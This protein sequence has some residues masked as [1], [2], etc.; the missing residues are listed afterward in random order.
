MKI[1]VDIEST[2][3]LQNGLDYSNL[4]YALK[5]DYKIWC[6]VFRNITTGEVTHLVKDKI[7]KKNMQQQLQ[8]CTELI[9]HN[10]VQFDLPVLMLYGVLDYRVG[11]PGEPTTVF[12]QEVTITDTLLWSKLLN[13]DR[14]GGHSLAVWGKRLGNYKEHFDDWANY[15]QEMLDYCIQDTFVNESIYLKLLEE[16]GQ[17][18]WSKPYSVEIKLADLTLRQELF[19]FDF[20]KE[21]AE[22][23]LQELAGFMQVIA[24]KVNPLLPLKQMPKSDYSFYIPPKVR[25]KKDGSISSHMD[26]FLT[27]L[28]ASLQD[29]NQSIV[30]EGRSFP[31]TTE[32]P[33][34]STTI[35]TIEDIDVVK[36]Y[37][38]GLGWFPTEIK[39]RDLVKNQD[40]TTKNYAQI[41]EAIDRYVKQTETSLFKELRL[42]MLETSMENLRSLLVS[43][44]DKGK[45]TKPIYVPSTPKL[46]VGVEKEI[47][48][49]LIALGEKAEFVKDVVHY[50]TYRHR[51]NSIAGG[52]LDDDGEPVTGF[53][54]A[55]REDG[56]IPTPADTLGANTGRYRHRVVCN[57]PRVT[58]LYGEQM[59]NLFGS[60]KGLW[61]LGYDFASLEARIMGHYVMPYKDGIELANALVAEKPNDIHSINAR[62]LGIERSAAKSFSYAAIYGAQP[63][64]L[65]KMLG[66]TESEGKKLFNDYW[67]AVPALKELKERVEKVWEKSGKKHIPGLDGRLLNTRSKHSLI[68]VLFQSGGAIAAKWSAVRLAQAMERE[69]ILGDPFKHT[70]KEKKI[71]W[72]IHMHDEQQMAGASSLFDVKV[73]K[74]DEEAKAAMQPGCSAIGHGAK[75]PYLAY[76]TKPV[77]CIEEGIASACKE[78]KLRVDLGFEYIVGKSW[79]QCH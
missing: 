5:P 35:A 37:L 50:Y 73:F 25:F 26:K 75:G 19:G 77:F 53:L 51:K 8:G 54:S 22:K 43:K 21:L 71:W 74:S 47:C 62:K 70:I 7:T 67:D 12:G 16:Q 29:N 6:V 52:V 64:K 31:V 17:H 49:N 2:N 61:Q 45:L 55:V 24:E 18:A 10:I 69:D 38:I 68:N 1:I 3:L 72:L 79:G 14:L 20:D 42:E 32:A 33:L 78:L 46:T 34:K 9:G 15:S 76:K 13:A 28:G 59:R 30:Y 11:Y 60:G 66:I 40:K 4:P 23:N 56:R 63:K 27:K 65:A 57:I 41:I 39:E 36:S 58:S 48:P 44:V